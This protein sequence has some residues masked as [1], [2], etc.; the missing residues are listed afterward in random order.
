MQL[1]ALLYTQTKIDPS[2]VH[3]VVMG[4]FKVKVDDGLNIRKV[5]VSRH[6]QQEATDS[7]AGSISVHVYVTGDLHE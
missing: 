3:E 4:P 2:L 7:F 1:Q 6:F 5:S